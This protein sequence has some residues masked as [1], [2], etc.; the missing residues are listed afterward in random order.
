[1]KSK[2]N[3][4]AH[5]VLALILIL[6]SRSPCDIKKEAILCGQ[7]MCFYTWPVIQSIKGWHQE[8]EASI[9]NKASSLAP[10]SFTFSNAIVVMYARAEYKKGLPE[11]KSLE[12]YIQK[13]K[14]IVAAQDSSI[15]VKMGLNIVNGDGKSLQTQTFFPKLQGNW[16]RV[17][18]SEETDIDGNEYFI[19]LTISSRTLMAYNSAQADYE[20]MIRNYKT[21]PK[22]QAKDK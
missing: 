1:L 12:Q 19:V 8:R 11:I 21:T 3:T 14:S 10:D 22:G 17:A 6:G 5:T 18:Y 7:Q 15:I 2:R 20:K 13:D 4:S 9:Q 16:E